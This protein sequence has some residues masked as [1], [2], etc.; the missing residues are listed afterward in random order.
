MTD[1]TETAT[2]MWQDQ[3]SGK[4]GHQLM[5][6]KVAATIPAIYANQNVA[7]YDTVLAHAKLVQPVQPVDVVYHRDG[8]QDR[9]VLRTGGGV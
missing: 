4:R 5:T 6:E 2:T 9:P 1:Q 7:D 8:R 3:H